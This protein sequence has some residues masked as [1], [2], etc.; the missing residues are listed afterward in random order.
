[1]LLLRPTTTWSD[2]GTHPARA[3][4]AH[5]AVGRPARKTTGSASADSNGTPSK[6]EE[7]ARLASTSGLR[8]NACLAVDGRRTPIGMQSDL[9]M[10][11]WH[12][13]RA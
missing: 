12:S 10:A 13:G 6:Q 11:A 9:P 7:S 8:L 2:T 4:A 5:Y 3:S 1:M